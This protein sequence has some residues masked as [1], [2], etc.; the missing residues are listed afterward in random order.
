M[1]EVLLQN[2]NSCLHENGHDNNKHKR[3]RYRSIIHIYSTSLDEQYCLS[4]VEIVSFTFG[5][6]RQK[7]LGLTPQHPCE[8]THRKS[9]PDPSGHNRTSF[10]PAPDR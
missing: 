2:T 7:V 10:S 4:D 5:F 8:V 6:G 3:S 9:T 1:Q